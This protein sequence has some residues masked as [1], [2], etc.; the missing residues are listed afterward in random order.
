MADQDL[1]LHR[2][3]RMEDLADRLAD[4][5]R[6]PRYL[7]ATPVLPQRVVVGSRGMERWL[8]QRIAERNGICSNVVF[9]FPQAILDEIVTG[10]GSAA[11]EVTVDPWTPAALAWRI[12]ELLE[13]MRSR[14]ELEP[15]FAYLGDEDAR[16]PGSPLQ[17]RRWALARQAADLLDS[18]A[19]QRPLWLEAWDRDQPGDGL[20]EGPV[21][22]WQR[23]LWLEARKSNPLH[24]PFPLRARRVLQALRTQAPAGP[25]PLH[26]FGVSSLPPLFVEL[27]SALAS[28][29]SPVSLYLFSPSPD[30]FADYRTRKTAAR[31]ADAASL[32]DAFESQNPLLT[33]LGRVSLEMQS[34]LLD[35]APNACESQDSVSEPDRAMSPPGCL[36]AHLQH[37]ILGLVSMDAMRKL[38]AQRVLDQ[39]DDSVQVHACHGPARQ[40]EVLRDVLLDLFERRHIAPREVVV[41]TPD[42]ETYAP[43]IQAVFQQGP[44]KR[45]ADETW[46]PDGSPQIPVEI[47][48]RSLRS[49][50]ALADA[51]LRLLEMAEGRMTAPAVLDLLGLFPVRWRAQ[52]SEEQMTTVQQ[53]TVESGVRWGADA[54][55]RDAAR[56]PDD[57]HNTWLFGLRRLALG[58]VMEAD[59]ELLQTPDGADIVATDGGQWDGAFDTE[60]SLLFGRF[61]A[62]VRAIVAHVRALRA[63][64]TVPQWVDAI[65]L[66][67][68]DLT[69]VTPSTSWLREQVIESLEALRDEA[70]AFDGEVSLPVI[71]RVLDG[72]FDVPRQGDRHVTGAVTVCSLQPMRN[73]PFRVVCL[74][75]MDDGSFPRPTND[76]GID[77]TRARRTP[78]DRDPRD[79]DRHLVLEALMAARSHFVVL[80]GA[81]D[82]HTNAE[83]PPAGPVADILDTI[84]LGF[85]PPA[86]G[87]SHE[88]LAARS[89]VIV[90]HGLQPF[91]AESFRSDERSRP[92]AGPS[93]DG[94]SRALSRALLALR[95]GSIDPFRDDEELD[96]PEETAVPIPALIDGLRH[97]AKL[98]LRTLGVWIPEQ[99][100]GGIDDREPMALEGL[101]AWQVGDRILRAALEAARTDGGDQAIARACDRERR[102]LAA[103]GLLPL[104]AAG[105]YSAK[106]HIDDATELVRRSDDASALAGARQLAIDLRID[107]DG[108]GTV[109]LQG[110][111]G[112]IT[113]GGDLIAL[114]RTD[115][116]A[117]KTLLSAWLQL[118]AARAQYGDEVKRACLIDLKRKGVWVLQ[119]PETPRELLGDLLA[120]RRLSRRRRIR[121]ADKTSFAVA[122]ELHDQD[123]SV[124]WVDADK[125]LLE[126]IIATVADK[127]WDGEESNGRT[128]RADRW[129]QLAWGDTLPFRDGDE[130]SKEFIRITEEVWRPILSR[131][132]E[133]KAGVD[134]KPP[135]E[136]KPPREPKVAPANDPQGTK[137]SRR[138]AS[139]KGAE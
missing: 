34:V 66:A 26:V 67:C 82:S 73:V 31:G 99:D 30:F 71:R 118:L 117:S 53:W 36:L 56:Q 22:A 125:E 63:P 122:S 11:P 119:P 3:H 123:L 62:T 124:A 21:A 107:V 84:D 32:D 127:T 57:D 91:G 104:G 44:D 113:L 58:V 6:H 10:L 83:K 128:D 14:P 45:R 64:R 95:G 33:S 50:N 109:S 137:P 9:H 121:L 126:Q 68:D 78:G 101:A 47:A 15:V 112:P 39:A 77:L 38:R 2:S 96:P 132:A 108:V 42:V 70:S 17:L 139:K 35:H 85:S 13:R 59:Q 81:R 27:F 92:F 5:L 48:D 106:S 20:P 130:V 102:A 88:P 138:R 1:L 54:A 120:L 69:T 23:A 61:A 135:K 37:D 16:G 90:D 60:G 24:D 79:E 103:E 131:T 87:S 49:V 28:P 129:V 75:G 97:P 7:P 93:F 25:G 76:S 46:G 65:T 98:V 89:H 86:G 55:D 136:P 72:R 43:L 115:A 52:L 110:E 40:V 18:Y 74:L 12:V 94:R 111:V 114:D 133:L 105:R 8:R 19:L 134:P 51:L 29:Q 116:R 41:M 80:Y 100:D 4:D